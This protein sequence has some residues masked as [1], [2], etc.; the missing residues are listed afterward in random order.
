MDTLYDPVLADFARQAFAIGYKPLAYEETFEQHL[1][2][3]AEWPRRWQSQAENLAAQIR[4]HPG[5][6][7]FAYVGFMQVPEKPMPRTW[8]TIESMPAR[9]KKLTGMDPLTIEQASVSGDTLYRPGRE[10]WRLVA[11]KLRRSSVLLVDGRPFPIGAIARATDIQVVHP[12][13]RFRYGRPTW[14]ASLRRFPRRVPPRLLPR[15]GRRLVQAFLAAEPR[16]AIPL[17]QVLVEAGKPVPRLMLPRAR[18]R[19]AVQDPE[20]KEAPSAASR[21]PRGGN[22]QGSRRPRSAYAPV[23]NRGWR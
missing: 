7:V 9:L 21:N 15:S 16:D 5:H 20:V 22:G 23:R 2:G 3:G 17:D 1:A 6:K 13:T 19:Y 18:I 4:L 10:A 8:G 12:R 14:L 11:P